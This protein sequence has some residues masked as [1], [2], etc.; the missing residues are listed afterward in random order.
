MK[1]GKTRNAFPWNRKVCL[2]TVEHQTTA[3]TSFS[4]QETQGA[5][6]AKTWIHHDLPISRKHDQD[7]FLE[8]ESQ[9]VVFSFT[10]LLHS[11]SSHNTK[12]NHNNTSVTTIEQRYEEKENESYSHCTSCLYLGTLWPIV[13]Y[14]ASSCSWSHG[15]W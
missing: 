11:S 13:Q 3:N 8:Q 15:P 2:W 10:E 4:H 7:Y 9:N 6:S 1:R 5:I 14:Y 12:N